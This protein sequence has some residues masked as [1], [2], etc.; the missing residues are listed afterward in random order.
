MAVLRRARLPSALEL[1]PFLFELGLEGSFVT[2]NMLTVLHGE[3]VMLVGLRK[4]F[5][6]FDGLNGGMVVILMDL[7][8]DGGGGLFMTMLGHSL[9]GHCRSNLFMNSGIMVSSL[10]PE[11]FVSQSDLDSQFDR[12]ASCNGKGSNVNTPRKSVQRG[13]RTVHPDCPKM[14]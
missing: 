2:M 12:R 7:A 6:V 3:N 14:F 11:Y 9:L 4:N 8:V 13:K 1:C 5:A 10:G